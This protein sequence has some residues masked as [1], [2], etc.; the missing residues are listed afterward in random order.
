MLMQ[1]LIDQLRF[2]VLGAWYALRRGNLRSRKI[3]PFYLNA[4][5]LLGEGAEIG[6]QRGLFSE[7]LLRY[8]K[9]RVLHGVDPWLPFDPSEYVERKDN[10]DALTHEVYYQETLQRL[11][12]FGDRSRV[13][14]LTSADAAPRIRDGSRDFVFIDAQ[15]HY[16][17]VKE[18]LGLWYPKLRAGGLLCGHDWPLDYGPP[19]FGV[20]KAVEEF[21]TSAQLRITVS[22]DGESWFAA[23]P[24]R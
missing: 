18:D 13:L 14:R 24:R 6:V 20:R 23:L 7:H 2:P 8:W 3:L 16:A 5:G 17:A 1:R 11:R 15:H 4:H 10:V 22:D 21:A 19:K 9:G 12:R